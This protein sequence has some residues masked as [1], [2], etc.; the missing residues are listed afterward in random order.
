MSE[1]EMIL[2]YENVAKSTKI[3]YDMAY[4]TIDAEMNGQAV[5]IYANLFVL[6][7]FPELKT[8]RQRHPHMYTKY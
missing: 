4:R 6:H 7:L 1:Q 8:F 5:L 3:S 2:R